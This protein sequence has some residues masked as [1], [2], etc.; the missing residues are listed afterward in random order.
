MLGRAAPHLFLSLRQRFDR[1]SHSAIRCAST[2]PDNEN[3]PHFENGLQF[4]AGVLRRSLP[5]LRNLSKY[6]VHGVFT[7][8]LSTAAQCWLLMQLYMPQ[9]TS[10]DLLEFIKGA[11]TATE[12]NLRAINCVDFSKSLADNKHDS[13]V[14]A[15]LK[16]YNTPA[17]Y[18]KL[19]LQVKKNY[20]HHSFYKECTAMKIEKTQLAGVTYQRLT[21]QDYKDWVT[22]TKPPRNNFSKATVE[23]L[24]IYLHVT[25]VEDLILV[26]LRDKPQYVQQHNVYRVVFESQVTNPADVDWRIENMHLI[27]QNSMSCAN[28]TDV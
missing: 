7:E 18:N 5:W 6:Q 16:Q 9:R 22:Y 3:P 23:H 28:E 13:H 21:Q 24:T 8:S 12:A 15:V 27:E 10:I 17:Y 1:V 4:I 14:V 19:A 25:T 2:L 26:F 20:L 11:K